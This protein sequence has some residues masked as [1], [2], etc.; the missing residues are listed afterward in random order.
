VFDDL[1]GIEFFAKDTT[2]RRL[3]VSPGIW[4]RLGFSS[5]QP[6]LGK[7]DRDLFPPYLADQYIRSDAQ[8]LASGQPIRGQL[9]VWVNEQGLPDWFI[10]TKYP[11]RGRDGSLIG[12]IGTLREAPQARRSA[13]GGSPLAKVIEHIRH[14]FRRPIAIPELTRVAAL[15][16]RHL[17]RRF[18]EEL[19]VGITE[20]ILKTRIHAAS[21]ELLHT[22]QSIANIALGVGFCDQSAFTRAF[23]ER[24]GITP[25][26]YQRRYLGSSAPRQPLP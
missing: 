10:V 8:L 16:E 20:F 26:E 14:H 25:R 4:R 12:I 24:M 22:H 15:S 13:D 3:Y 21:S 11:V 18:A 5:A 9:E 2:G 1:P 7:H 6:M 17:R 23:R 19:G